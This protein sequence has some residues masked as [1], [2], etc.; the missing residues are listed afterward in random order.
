[1]L[2]RLRD[3]DDHRSWQR[4]FEQYWRLIYSFARKCGLE[5]GDAEDVVQEVVTE[6]FR[7]MPR[8]DYDRAKGTFRAYL[9]TI[10]RRKITDHLRKSARSRSAS[11][12]LAAR[13]GNGH[14]P[15][16][17]PAGEAADKTWERDWRRNL[18]QVCLERVSHEVEPKTFQAFQLFALDGWSAA[19]TAAFLKMNVGSVY[20]AKSRVAAR[21][22]HWYEREIGEDGGS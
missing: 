12:A 2:V 13:G 17:D 14:A 8:F 22:R 10:S 5:P 16:A 15:L 18:L 4:F 20:V 11:A 19:D 21:V 7:T 1:L 6:V 3:A 9:R